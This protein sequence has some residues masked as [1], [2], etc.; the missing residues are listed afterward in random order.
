[1]GVDSSRILPAIAILAHGG[2]SLTAASLD[3]HYF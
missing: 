1:M 3:S 2:C